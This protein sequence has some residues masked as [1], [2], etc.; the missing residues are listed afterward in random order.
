MTDSGFKEYLEEAI[1][2][3]NAAVAFSAFGAPASV[4][5]RLNPFKTVPEEFCRWK[6]DAE[7]V[8]WSRH[9]LMLRQ[10]PVFTLDP[11]LHAGAYYVQ[12]SSSMFT[13]EVFRRMAGQYFPAERLGGRPLRVLDLC[14]APGGKTTDIAASLREM[15]GDK[16][17]LVANEALRQRAG[18]LADNLAIWGEAN[19]I[20]TNA[21]PAAFA[22]LG[23]YF[24]IILADVPCSGEG[25][26]RKDAEAVRQWSRD[27]VALCQARQR[28]ILADVWPALSSGGVLVYSTCTFNR[29]ENDFNAE[30]IIDSLGAAISCVGIFDEELPDSGIIRTEYGFS[31]VPG[32][33]KGEGQYCTALVKE[34]VSH[35]CFM[36]R[37]RNG[38]AERRANVLDA[39]FNTSVELRQRGNFLIALPGAV[40]QEMEALAEMLHPM[41]AGCLAGEVKGKDFVPSADLALSLIG[42]ENAFPRVELGIDDALAFLHRDSIVLPDSPKGY[43]QVCYGGLP[44]GF[45]KNLGTRCNNLHPQGRRIRMDVRNRGL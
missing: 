33:V 12:D 9:G 35:A 26:F 18:T 34:T 17:I 4:S 7:P 31:L 2:Q 30:W 6:A 45:V 36:D 22:V 39:L 15:Y 13:G 37:K 24:D 20:V 40:A 28:R 11:C 21:D 42:D 38:K 43:I 44:L 14:A 19:V 32:L 29:H 1:G 41:R 8:Q 10:R 23:G 16:F 3:G 27:N 25:M 5:V